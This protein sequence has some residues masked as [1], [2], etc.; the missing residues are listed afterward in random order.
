MN[1]IIPQVLEALKSYEGSDFIVND[2][3]LEFIENLKVDN[4]PTTKSFE[5]SFNLLNQFLA[6]LKLPPLSEMVAKADWGITGGE[7]VDELKIWANDYASD[8]DSEKCEA[9][10]SWRYEH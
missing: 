4:K 7:N 3:L 6:D 8:V 9:K 10:E 2:E 1:T 5:E